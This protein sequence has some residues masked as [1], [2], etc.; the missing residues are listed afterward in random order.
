MADGSILELY[1]VVGDAYRDGPLLSLY[2]QHGDDAYEIFE[3]R[4]LEASGAAHYHVH[5]IF[6][7][8]TLTEARAHAEDFG[9]RILQIDPSQVEDLQQDSLEINDGNYYTRHPV[10]ASAITILHDEDDLV[11]SAVSVWEAQWRY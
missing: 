5:C 2:D 4:W 9:S 1:H 10:P 11:R 7:Y 6:F 8:E 3:A